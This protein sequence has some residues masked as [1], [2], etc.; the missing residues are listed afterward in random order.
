MLKKFLKAAGLIILLFAA[1]ELYVVSFLGYGIKN[2]E[3]DVQ[4][5]LLL[6]V[7]PELQETS[8]ACGWGLYPAER[9]VR[10]ETAS[11]ETETVWRNGQRR[12]RSNIVKNADKKVCLIGCSYLFGSGLSD[13]QTMAWK[14]NE[15]Y[16]DICFD[17]YGVPGWGT[18]QCY[19]L[20]KRLLQ[21][22]KYD[23]I[24]Y[25]AINDHKERNTKYKF[26]GSLK[27][28]KRYVMYPRIDI[29]SENIILSGTEF[30][31]LEYKFSLINFLHRAYIGFM[32]GL[33]QKKAELTVKDGHLYDSLMPKREK[34]FWDLVSMMSDEAAKAGTNFCLCLLEGEWSQW[35]YCPPPKTAD[36]DIWK[37]SWPEILQSEYR[38]NHDINEHPNQTANDIWYE[39]FKDCFEKK[40]GKDGLELGKRR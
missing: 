37:L 21:L 12:S 22:H 7:C 36:Y 11:Q 40:Y 19:I 17:N 9:R 8:R 34:I 30:W 29:D 32:S 35:L 4:G 31:P 10:N 24:C 5:R 14:L 13:E 3:K 27:P 38:I 6:T 28:G 20:E 23:L 1:A 25:C 16:P 15:H 18:L 33:M 39:K 2:L 26:L